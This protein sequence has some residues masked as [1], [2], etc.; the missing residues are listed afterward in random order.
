MKK[1]ILLLL[2]GL[3]AWQVNAQ[4]SNPVIAN[5]QLALV[6]VPSK[7]VKAEQAVYEKEY[8]CDGRQ[9]CTQMNSRAEALFFLTHCPNTKMDGDHDGVPCENDS[10]F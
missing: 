6:N 7:H 8:S 9:Y 10:R 4:Q 2:I 1:L 5:A 3:T